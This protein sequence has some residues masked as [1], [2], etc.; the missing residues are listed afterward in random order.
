[1]NF[2]AAKTLAD[3]LIKENGAAILIN[4][5]ASG[6]GVLLP[7][8]KGYQDKIFGVDFSMD[9]QHYA[10]V[11]TSVLLVDGDLITVAGK[12]Y[13]VANNKPVNPNTTTLI[14]QRVALRDT[15]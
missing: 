7:V 9:S 13:A 6:Y 5:L 2:I 8:G 11:S 1:M 14:Y 12:T 10:L 15:Q 3:R 4:G